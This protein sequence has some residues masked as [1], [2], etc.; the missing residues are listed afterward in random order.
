[1]TAISEM[2]RKIAVRSPEELRRI[3]E[4]SN[5]GYSERVGR[6]LGTMTVAL[7]AISDTSS[8]EDLHFTGTGTLVTVGKSHYILTAAHVWED[9]LK[10]S[11]RVGIT[12]KEGIDHRCAIDTMALSPYGPP[13]LPKRS[14][15]G[16]DLVFLRI[17]EIHLGGINAF[18]TFYSLDKDRPKV[19]SDGIETRV[20]MGAPA[21][22]EKRTPKHSELNI[23]GFFVEFGAPPF[24][25][26]DFDY[27]ELKEAVNHPGIPKHFGGVSGGG[28]WLV[29]IF[30]SPETLQIDWLHFLEGVA[31]YQ[32]GIGAPITTIRCHAQE[33]IR[34][35]MKDV[36]TNL[37]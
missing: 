30:E 23:N 4:D 25:R 12:L 37:K 20:L 7:F 9:G 6:F 1:M 14:E 3:F 2:K 18:K 15:W 28:L 33:S 13:L 21:E 26:G 16:P 29:Q 5:S 8:G 32:L 22:F 27:V 17:P 24:V 10:S 11:D 35:A 34:A 31:F 19:K 36:P